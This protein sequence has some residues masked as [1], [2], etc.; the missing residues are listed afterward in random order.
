M[1]KLVLLAILMGVMGLVVACGAEVRDSG[2]G[3]QGGTGGQEGPISLAVVPKA[4]G[5]SFW[6]TVQQ[7]AQC[8]ASR[9]EDVSIQWDGVTQETNVNGQV[10]LLQNFVSQGV[11]GIVYAATDA[12]VLS[13]VTRNA[14]DQGIT[15]VN[16]DSG[17]TPQPDQVPVFATDNVEAAE[18]VP[19]LLA[20]RIGSEGGQIAFIPFQQGTRTNEAREEGFKRGLEDHPELELV[21]EQSSQSNYNTALQVTEDILTAN[22]DLDGI[23][24]ANEPGALGAAEAVRAAGK[25]GEI[26]IIGWDASS[27][28]VE[29]LRGGTIDVLI[30]QNPFRM[31]FDGVNAAVETIRTGE[32]VEGGD[33]GTTIVTEQNVDDPEVQAVLNPSCDNIPDSSSGGTTSQ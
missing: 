28:E 14:L 4:I 32:T 26:T 7:G 1:R 15:V 16:I 13:R 27:E 31:G 10:D 2:G 17:T 33:T 19:D 25:S 18:N 23:F 11:D 9:E 12:Q 30:V 21:A 20:E 8:A 6:D 29:A 24:A 5:F 22:P 3:D